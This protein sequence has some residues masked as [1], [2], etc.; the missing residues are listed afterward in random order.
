MPSDDEVKVASF[1]CSL[2]A[3]TV[4]LEV[5]GRR[6]YVSFQGP[7]V[8]ANGWEPYD[9]PSRSAYVPES[10]ERMH[11]IPAAGGRLLISRRSRPGPA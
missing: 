10:L 4:E 2:A 1:D 6:L 9:Q 11:V 3:V 8:V 5:G 7:A